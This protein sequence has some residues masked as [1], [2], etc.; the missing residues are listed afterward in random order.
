MEHVQGPDFPTGGLCIEPANVL[1]EAY[2]TGRGS[3]RVRAG[4]EVESLPRGQWQI[5]VTEIPYQVQKARLIE[6]I[7]ELM[8]ARALPML[9]DIR[10]ES[11]EDIRIVIMPKSKNMDADQVM[12]V[13]FKQTDLES[14]FSLNMNVLDSTGVPRVMGLREALLEWLAHGQVVLQRKSRF[15]LSKIEARLEI[16]DSYLVAYLNLDEV[17]RIIREED[18]PRDE[19]MAA[20]ALNQIQADAI[21]NLR[22]RALRKLEEEGIRTE[23]KELT[24]EKAA[25]TKLL[26]SDDAQTKVISDDIKDLRKAYGPKTALSKRRTLFEEVAETDAVSIDIF[27]EKEPV[28]IGC[29]ERLDKGNE[30]SCRK[31]Q[32]ADLQGWRP[33]GLCVAR[34]KHG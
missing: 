6:K 13:L 5:V 25:L 11:A 26:K 14:R 19:L 9:E 18:E 3:L 2:A 12:G 31:R 22:L 4:Y 23:H 15:R 1:R 30:G 27:I 32:G 33:R 24:A 8:Q 21:L 17:I 10:D 7:A 34:A 29:S 20:F 28:T 16:L